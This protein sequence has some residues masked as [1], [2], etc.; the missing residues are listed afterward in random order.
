MLKGKAGSIMVI[1]QL[2]PRLRFVETPDDRIFQRE[3]S[4]P[5]DKQGKLPHCCQAAVSLGY[6]LRKVLFDSQPGF[7]YSWGGVLRDLD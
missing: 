6:R 3:V 4:L 1:D 7:S 5:S 2:S